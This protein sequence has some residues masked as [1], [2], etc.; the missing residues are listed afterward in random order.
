MASLKARTVHRKARMGYPKDRT[1]RHKAHMGLLGVLTARHKAPTVRLKVPM[2]RLKALTASPNSL[3]KARLGVLASF[4]LLAF[5]RARA[6][7][8]CRAFPACRS[9]SA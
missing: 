6:P 5:F 7:L 8:V 1:V 9:R 2:V 4:L 3:L